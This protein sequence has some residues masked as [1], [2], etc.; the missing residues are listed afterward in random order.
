MVGSY[1]RPEP[2]SQHGSEQVREPATPQTV[3]EEVL[4]EL[5]DREESPAHNTATVVGMVAVTGN[6]YDELKD[7]FEQDLIYFFGEALHNSSVSP[8]ASVSPASPVSPVAPVSPVCPEFPPSLPLPSPQSASSSAPVQLLSASPSAALIRNVLP[9]V[10][11]PAASSSSMDPLSPPPAS[12]PLLHLC[13]VWL[14]LPP[15]SAFIL[16]PTGSASALRISGLSSDVS[17]RGSSSVSSTIGVTG[18]HRLIGTIWVSIC[19]GCISVGR[20]QGVSDCQSV[21]S[22]MALP[23]F[24]SALGPRPGWTLKS[25][26]SRNPHSD[27][28]CTNQG[29]SGP[30][31]PSPGVINQ[32]RSLQKQEVFLWLSGRASR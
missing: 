17:H 13:F 1:H 12:V 15:G 7:I 25:W 10:C 30:L 23:A 19:G 31:F 28:L 8:M 32:H 26:D 2:A 18:T 6:Y 27:R 22:T 4:V 29:N 9:S 14:L 21:I 24:N 11:R 5:G 16:C 3:T 20:L